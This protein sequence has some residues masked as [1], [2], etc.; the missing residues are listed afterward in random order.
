MDP[1]LW[2]KVND[3]VTEETKDMKIMGNDKERPL[4]VVQPIGEQLQCIKL[5]K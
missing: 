2:V 5:R 4:T 3:P 1:A